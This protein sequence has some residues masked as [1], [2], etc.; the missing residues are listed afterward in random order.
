M[1]LPF[2]S[3]VTAGRWPA[4]LLAAI[5]GAAVQ[6]PWPVC[7]ECGGRGW[8]VARLWPAPDARGAGGSVSGR[9]G[10]WR[11][12]SAVHGLRLKAAIFAMFL[13]HFCYMWGWCEIGGSVTGL[14]CGP[15][16]SMIVSDVR[17]FKSIPKAFSSR[18]PYV[19][20]DRLSV[21][22]RGHVQSPLV[23]YEAVRGATF[24][25]HDPETSPHLELCTVP[26][27]PWSVVMDPGS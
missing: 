18:F 20:S 19:F 15:S 2:W 8:D 25:D 22:A 24:D 21:L 27:P 4:A 6:M 10:P 9:E 26:E 12:R 5:D 23:L 17:V 16:F 14:W 3:R 11:A 7:M 1:Q 13:D